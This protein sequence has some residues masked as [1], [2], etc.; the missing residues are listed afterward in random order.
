M[1][2]NYCLLFSLSIA[3]LLSSLARAKPASSTGLFTAIHQLAKHINKTS[4][5][6]ADQISRQTAIIQKNIDQVGQTS[7]IIGEAL[8]LV[9]S[10]ETTAGPLFMNQATRGGFPRKPAGGLELDRAMFAV[11]QGLMDY[12]ASHGVAAQAALQEIID[13][14]FPDGRPTH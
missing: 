11:Q 5:L 4:T 1:R 13:V 14:Y 3:V 8:D 2:R 7:E 10:Y 6:D 9:A 12:E